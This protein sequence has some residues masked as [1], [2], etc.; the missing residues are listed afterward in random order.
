M[1]GCATLVWMTNVRPFTQL[2]DEL[3]RAPGPPMPLVIG[4]AMP[5][6]QLCWPRGCARLLAAMETTNSGRGV[7]SQALTS[8][9]PS[10]TLAIFAAASAR[11]L[12]AYRFALTSGDE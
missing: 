7:A 9:P 5:F 11:P 2:A 10:D 1:H 3:I 12:L 6:A 8:Q 4:G